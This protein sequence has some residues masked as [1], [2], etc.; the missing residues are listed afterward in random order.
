MKSDNFIYKIGY[1]KNLINEMNKS[2]ITSELLLCINIERNNDNFKEQ[3]DNLDLKLINNKY[4]T[5]NTIDIFLCMKSINLTE[6][7]Y[8][9]I[10]SS[11]NNFW[12]DEDISDVVSYPKIL[13]IYNNYDLFKNDIDNNRRTIDEIAKYC[14]VTTK[15]LLLLL[16]KV[17][18]SRYSKFVLHS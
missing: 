3:I 4:I 14:N 2:N 10:N 12:H 15:N 16:Y 11:H 6:I 9:T 8:D 17:P 7:F 5:C 1:T 13:N 18:Y